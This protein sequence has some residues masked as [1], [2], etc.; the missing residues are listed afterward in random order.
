MVDFQAVGKISNT[1]ASGIG[2]RDHNDFV[3]A[4]NELLKIL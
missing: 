3:P 4:I 1:G 2:M